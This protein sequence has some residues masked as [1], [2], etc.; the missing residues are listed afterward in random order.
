MRQKDFK[1]GSTKRRRYKLAIVSI[2]IIMSR[3]SLPLVQVGI[4]EA[5][6]EDSNVR[7]LKKC[8][9]PI[10]QTYVIANVFSNLR[11]VTQYRF[12]KQDLGTIVDI[13]N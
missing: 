12:K 1:V 10:R 5:L 13:I 4:V 9:S 6:Y 7:Y 8:S 11:S 2:S 3:K